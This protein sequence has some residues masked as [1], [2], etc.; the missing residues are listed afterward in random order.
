MLL[1]APAK[2]NLYLRIL[3]LRSDGYHELETLFEKID[4]RDTVRLTAAKA[5]VTVTSNEKSL[6]LGRANICYRAAELVKNTC[7]I[8]SGVKIHITKKIP[9]A[10]GLG[11]GSSD[12][13]S[14]LK[15]LNRLWRLGLTDSALLTLANGLG[16]DLAFFVAKAS[17]GIGKGRGER[18]TAYPCRLRLWHVVITPPLRL[19]TKD[20]YRLYDKHYGLNLT[21]RSSIDRILPPKGSIGTRGQ[22]GTLLYNDLE[23]IVLIQEPLI[24]HIK[25]VLIGNGALNALLSGSGSSVF[26]IYNSKNEAKKAVKAF[27]WAIHVT[28]AW[29]VFIARTY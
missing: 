12:G 14:V 1:D 20:I 26:G 15:G 22:V 19:L 17:F 3:R 7:K 2:V 4:I 5:G 11:G 28:R 16:S 18:V 23:N 13:V 6:P 9:I 25:E 8:K 21:R 10:A 27:F 24:K 29:R